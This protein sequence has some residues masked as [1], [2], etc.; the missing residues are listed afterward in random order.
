MKTLFVILSMLLLVSCNGGG[1][2]SSGPQLNSLLYGGT[3]VRQ[4]D[5]CPGGN[6]GGGITQ[7]DEELTFSGKT[8][9]F[10][11]YL[12]GTQNVFNG[13]DFQWTLTPVDG[14][15]VFVS[16]GTSSELYTYT[17]DANNLHVCDPQNNCLDYTR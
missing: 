5:W 15:H 12:R 14:S 13:T 7:L 6:C 9:S 4:W 1:S 8:A 10:Q 2:G 11:S 17:V 3:W 16:D